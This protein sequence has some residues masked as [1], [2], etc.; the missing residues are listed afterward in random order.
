MI[1]RIIIIIKAMSYIGISDET[2]S[3]QVHVQ[4]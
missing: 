2:L 4:V 3:I 1:E